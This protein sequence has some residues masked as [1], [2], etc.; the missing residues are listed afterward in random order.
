MML[1]GTISTASFYKYKHVHV[2]YKDSQNV[3]TDRFLVMTIEKC[4]P[5]SFATCSS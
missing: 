5:R 2:Q 4:I 3:V 1:I